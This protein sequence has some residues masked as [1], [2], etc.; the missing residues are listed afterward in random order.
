MEENRR[1][2]CSRNPHSVSAA[3]QMPLYVNFRVVSLPLPSV[4]ILLKQLNVEGLFSRGGPGGELVC[5]C[6]SLRLE[7]KNLPSETTGGG[8]VKR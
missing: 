6:N 8:R 3:L 4:D 2:A 5:L 1:S 7:I